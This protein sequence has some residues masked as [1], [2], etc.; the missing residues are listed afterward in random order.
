MQT[1]T[2]VTSGTALLAAID[3]GQVVEIVAPDD[4]ILWLAA[5][6]V[7]ASSGRTDEA[8]EDIRRAG[9]M[10]PALRRRADCIRAELAI[11]DGDTATAEGLAYDVMA[12]SVAHGDR[13]ACVR[14]R[15]AVARVKVRDGRYQSALQDLPRLRREIDADMQ[16]GDRL[17]LERRREHGRH[18]H[19]LRGSS[20]PFVAVSRISAATAPSVFTAHLVA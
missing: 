14:A 6:E 19:S 7:A 5:A 3:A 18:R 8:L 9:E 13:T 17:L 12:S 1:R 15:I 10:S 11:G 2:D 4:P 16:Q 20:P